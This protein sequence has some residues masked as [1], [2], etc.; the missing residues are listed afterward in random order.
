MNLHVW[1]GDANLFD[2]E[3]HEFLALLEVEG[4]DTFSDA[5]GEGFNFVRQAVVDREFL[6]LRQECVALLL[7]SSLAADHLLMPSLELGELNRLHLIEIHEPSLFCRG[8]LQPL[9][10]AFKLSPQQFIIG[11]LRAGAECGLALDQHLRPQQCL[12]KLF[13]HE[14]VK[15]LRPS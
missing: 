15:R 3:A 4:V 9:L 8:A 14:R 10:Q 1:P 12:A 13:P 6:V 5:P 7:E 11:L 2:Q